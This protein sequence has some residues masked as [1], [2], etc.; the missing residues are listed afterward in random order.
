[1]N[2]YKKIL[3]LLE[4]LESHMTSCPDRILLSS[5]YTAQDHTSVEKNS[6]KK[7]KVLIQNLFILRLLLYKFWTAVKPT[8]FSAAGKKLTIS[9]AQRKTG[10][11]SGS[12]SQL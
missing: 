12:K 10:S 5:W 7:H 11:V 8:K 1:M 9:D 4:S 2:N 3:L 6:I